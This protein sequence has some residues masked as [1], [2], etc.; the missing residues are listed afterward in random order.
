MVLLYN[1]KR[2]QVL[3]LN[4]FLTEFEEHPS[5]ETGVVCF[6]LITLQRA[7]CVPLY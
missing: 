2:E 1:V 4:C 6:Y 7:D 5:T 3:G